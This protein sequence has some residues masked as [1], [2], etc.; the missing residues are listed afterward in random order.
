MAAF[1]LFQRLRSRS[2]WRFNLDGPLSAVSRRLPT[3]VNDYSTPR[4]QDRSSTILSSF[5]NVI[6]QVYSQVSSIHY[7]PPLVLLTEVCMTATNSARLLRDE[8]VTPPY[9]HIDDILRYICC[10]RILPRR[11]QQE[12]DHQ[13]SRCRLPETLVTEME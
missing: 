1:L 2:A 6:T 9:R 12:R 13:L 7:V 3:M 11:T 5:V 8:L 4:R 10:H